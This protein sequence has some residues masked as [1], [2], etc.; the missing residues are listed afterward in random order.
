MEFAEN[1][2]LEN[3]RVLKLIFPNGVPENLRGNPELDN[4]LVKLG[5]CKVEQLKKEQTRLADETKRILEQT[6][7]LAITN[8]KTFITT[9]E[10]SRSIFHEFQ[11]AEEQVDT[12]KDKLPTFSAKCHEFLKKS[13]E[14]TEQRR[15][16]STTLHKNAQLLE[17]LELPQLM[18]RCIREGRYEEAL[19]LASY[20]Q[21]LGQHQGQTIPVVNGIV[22]SVEALWHTMLVQLVAQ[23]RM[24][25]QLPKCLQI[26]GYLRRM[27][28]FG[29]NEL[30]LKFLQARDAWLTSCLDAIPKTDAQQHLT[31]TIEITRINLFNIITQYR[32]IFPEGEQASKSAG[33]KQLSGVSCNGLRLFEAWLH[34]KID[35]FLL[36]LE[37]DL[38]RGINSIETVLGQC[39]YFGLSFSRIGADFR[40]L[41]APIFV[42]VVRNKFES[43][44]IKV[45]E[46]FD[47]ELEKFTLINKV[48][49]HTRKQL[50][51][52]ALSGSEPDMES[53]APP[54]TLLDF[55]PLAVLCNGYLNALNELRLC[56]PFAVATDVTSC[57]QRSL[58]LVAKQVLAFYRQEQQAFTRNERETFVKL[59]SCFAYDLVPYVQRCIHGVFPPQSISVHLGISLLQL[60]QHQLTYLMQAQ[61]LEPLKHLLPTK[62]L[63][64]SS[65]QSTAEL[66][67]VSIATEG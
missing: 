7:E 42:R 62:V 58:E 50:D 25:L 59:C 66:S 31:K 36:T 10:N 17:I 55:Y 3:D 34:N 16:N 4:Y 44:I 67:S 56:A 49:L 5:T 47:R 43:S 23:M 2:D 65:P 19:E 46:N 53:Y 60:E 54:E 28:A 37:E 1:M 35:A 13:A 6:Q 57:L 52:A 26:V 32:A 61:I 8:Y 12:L 24:D 45:N 22:R 51:T 38:Q 29:D 63:I 41:I 27:Q 11:K 14:L 15:L 21:R 18:E 64:H 30:K 48:S 20:V 9:A 40:A 39:M 33:L